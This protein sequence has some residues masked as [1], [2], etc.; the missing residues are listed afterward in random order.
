MKDNFIKTILTFVFA[1][2]NL[3]LS[4][5]TFPRI[6][7]LNIDDGLPQNTVQSIEKDPFGFMW[8]GTDNGL[9]RYDGYS[10][11]YYY[12]T[13]SPEDLW[14]NQILDLTA[15]QDHSLWI[16]SRNGLQIFDLL[17]GKFK[18]IEQTEILRIFKQ[19]IT[20]TYCDNHSIW[21]ITQ[22][23]GVYHL[24]TNNDN[25]SIIGHYLSDNNTC[26]PLCLH[27]GTSNNTYLGTD[28]GLYI[29]DKNINNFKP[30]TFESEFTINFIQDIFE[31]KH[32]LYLATYNGLFDYN[33]QSKKLDWYNSENTNP[34][35][36]S[37][38]NITAIVKSKPNEL[39]I[40]T[41]GGF[42]RLD[43]ET[44]KISQI[45]IFNKSDNSQQIEFIRALYNDEHGNIWVGTEKIG[46]AHYN[47]HQKNFKAIDYQTPEAQILNQDIINSIYKKNHLLWVG[48][49][50]HGLVRVNTE[51]E[52]I[53]FYRTNSS[54]L[55]IESDFITSI[56][57]DKTGNLWV[58]T[59]GM[60]LQVMK[61]GNTSKFYNYHIT[62]GLPSD[63]V[64]NIS[65]TKKGDMIVSTQNG[66]CVYNEKQDLFFPIGPSK[67]GQSQIWKVGCFLEDHKGFFWVGTT[68][69]LHRF[70]GRLV[71]KTGTTVIAPYEQTWFTESSKKQSLPNNYITSVVEDSKGNIWVGTYGGGIAQCIET[72]DGN[73]SFNTLTQKNGLA[74]NVVYS[75]LCDD[76]DNLWITTENGLSKYSQADQ[77]F[78]NYYK[79][80][81]LRNNQYYWSSSFKDKDGTLYFGGLNGLNYCHPHNITNYPFSAN[82][83]ITAL[84]IFNN[85]VSPNEIYN[86]TIPLTKATFATDTILLSYK[87]NSFSLE[88]SALNYLHSSKIKY[89]YKLVG[90][91]KDWI[92]ADAKQR[93]AS[94]TNL[95]GGDY[96]FQVKSTNLE[97]QWSQKITEVKLIIIPPYWQTL[98]FK[99]LTI[100]IFIILISGY[101][102]YRSFRISAQKKRLEQLVK[103][104]TLEIEEKNKQL[105]DNAQ[106]LIDS[107]MQLEHRSAQIEQQKTQLEDQNKEIISQ[108][109]Q[110]LALNEEIEGIHQM[111][112]QFFT[113]ISHEFRTPLTLILSPV[114]RLI[115]ESK[116]AFPDAVMSTLNVIKRN[117]DRLLLLTNQ[118]LTFRKMEAG[119]LKVILNQGKLNEVVS[120]IA[121]AFNE[122]ANKKNIDYQINIAEA[123]YSGYYDKI[124]LENILFNLLSNAF[125]FTSN[126]GNVSL[127]LKL[128]RKNEW[129]RGIEI[130]VSDTGDGIK[131]EDLA[132]VFERFYRAENQIGSGTGIGLSLVKEL[133][134]KQNGTITAQSEWGE[135]TCFTITLPIEEKGFSDY[136]LSDKEV[137]ETLSLQ[138]KVDLIAVPIADE[139]ND[140]SDT[141][142]K[143]A[144]LIIE[145]NEDLRNFLAESLKNTYRIYTAV[146]G[147]DGYEKALK[148]EIDLIISDIMM[149]KLNGLDLCKQLKNNLNTSHL[150]IILLSA[151]G[152]QENQIEGLGVGAD[153][154]I[155]KP[156]NFNILQAK[157]RSTIENR[158][159]LKKIY[160]NDTSEEIQHKPQSN[161]LDEEFMQKVNLVVSECYIDPSFDIETFSS[162]MFVSRSLLYKKLK[163]LTN[164]SP[165]EYINVFRLKKS[166]TL[167]KSK[168]YQIAEVAVMVGFNDPKYFSR[169]FKKF[170]KCSPSEYT[171]A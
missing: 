138:D 44:Q 80:D 73:Y 86:K 1:S 131:E 163:A 147:E 169:V 21:I 41:L 29:F 37:H 120:E 88:F 65:F 4:S 87:D 164:V 93:I 26:Q 23:N 11:K 82:T 99:L 160:L 22:T 92:L 113:N 91:D 17:K 19:D 61:K 33:K 15:D 130:Q 132:K 161:T 16:T 104:R 167:I 64:S 170:Y 7:Y 42:C 157:L 151:K 36:I 97:G 117:A 89:A 30:Y 12:S 50:G 137:E 46:L 70:N 52:K 158:N 149:P 108:R 60:G 111:R 62:K 109:D 54:K 145:D 2:A 14:D 71:S 40:G 66:L 126:E 156:F 129:G 165:N 69:G 25:Y 20:K 98:W 116:N 106:R 67:E 74:N 83:S 159:K 43:T 68:D 45:N 152:M 81:G 142:N 31:D 85:I 118:I 72:S 127:N 35:R 153:D 58:A 75:I 115:N 140:D 125:K 94:Y 48:T 171:G 28:Q 13:G 112:M 63:F 39:L 53:D 27:M 166:I 47:I 102:Q 162:K 148:N 128:I 134:E 77:H 5:Q 144:L 3:V 135:G 59:W 123:D 24:S 124:K 155:T 119:K 101:I 49:A 110:L 146:D 105:E 32:H 18:T 95:A 8:F 139:S 103:D 76:K 168:K 6:E 122:L 143:P 34:N 79:Q 121:Q 133:I 78:I 90:F 154:Y 107:N 56:T 55:P 84:K 9:C 136:T 100:I 57:E 96:T 51:N 38:P 114:E 150:P 10:F 141:P